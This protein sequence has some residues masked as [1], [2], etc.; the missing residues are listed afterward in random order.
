MVLDTNILIAYLNNELKVV[1]TLSEWRQGGRPIFISSISVAEILSLPL[2]TQ[3]DLNK[4]K[5][6]LS[7]FISVPF[8]DSL[9]QTAAFIRRI[10][11]LG[12]PDAAIAATALLRGIPL[13]TRDHQF[14][15]IQ[16]IT[17]IEL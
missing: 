6:F 5:L 16:E 8:D 1:E 9:A 10:Y 17:I 13:V 14:R 15:K 4:I 2:I 7:N 12:I 11:H 3:S